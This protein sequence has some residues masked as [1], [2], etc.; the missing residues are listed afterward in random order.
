MKLRQSIGIRLA[1]WTLIL[2]GNLELAASL[3]ALPAILS[4]PL[5]LT[6]VEGSAR[7]EYPSGPS[8]WA[9]WRNHQGPDC[10]EKPLVQSLST[11]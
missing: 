6:V 7:L 4:L 2:T 9:A 8:E 10:S 11:A 3:K 1:Q 5:R